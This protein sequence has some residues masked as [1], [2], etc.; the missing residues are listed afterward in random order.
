MAVNVVLN[1]VSYSIPDPG[2]TAWG[3]DLTDYFVAQASGLLQKAG[4]TF[5]LTAEVDFG[6]TFGLKSAYFKSRAANPAGAGQVRL[7]NTEVISWRNFANDGNLS[8]TV[9]A[10]NLLAFNGTAIQPAGNYIT[11]LTG[12]VTASGPGS[13]AATL[14]A[15]SNATLTTLS[16]L[17]SAASLATVGTITSGVW[18][19]TAVAYAYVDLTGSV[20]NADISNSAA[21]D[22][23]KLAALTA[24]RALQSS[25]GGVIEPS[26]VTSTEL[27]YLSGVTSA[28]QTQLDA[29]TLKSTLTTKGDIYAATASATPARRA[30][31]NDGEV[32]TA[33]SADPTG[34]SWSAP[35][36]N[37]M[38][39]GGD[40]IYGGA[41]G[42]ATKLANGTANQYLAS[43]GGT[44]AP[45]WTTFVAPTV[46][47]FTSGSGTYTLPS[48]PRAPLYIRVRMVGGGGGGGGS[49][50]SSGTAATAGGASTFGAAL[51]S[52][53][54]GGTGGRDTNGGAG[55]TS[56]LGAGPVGTALTGG[57]GGGSARQGSVVTTATASLIGGM[58]ASSALGGGGAGGS[59]GG[60]GGGTSGAANTGG[61]GGGG[62][63]DINNNSCTG[64]GAGSGGF[65]DAIISAP[66]ATY[67]YAVGTGGTGQAAGTVGA[68]GGNGGS[69]YIEVTEYYQ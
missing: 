66:A 30:V 42:A 37:P 21:I 32:L 67:A 25:A 39:A 31:G 4:G 56:S 61:G 45:V 34:L 54:G 9:N 17:T 44:S 62:Y 51:L 27:G 53:G 38:D 43:A 20:V 68:A 58:G 1:G 63:A 33:D 46:Q 35:L 59:G 64:S 13:V 40:L 24:S 28:V 69:G 8:L 11:A 18:N 57:I 14:A 2:D 26:A 47:K 7:G 23:S 52:A 16:A 50:T 36:V 29:K 49:G 19:G 15:T 6:A 3:Q 22:Y 10:S 41:L 48:S 60:S 55:G 5:S 65:V 12:D